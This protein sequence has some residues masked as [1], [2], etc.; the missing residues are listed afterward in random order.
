[1]EYMERYGDV[2]DDPRKLLE[3]VQSII[4]CAISYYT[5]FTPDPDALRI[6]RYALG[7]DYH[8]IVRRRL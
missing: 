5:P 8:D 1:M 4:C 6:A 7:Q 2:R 3:G